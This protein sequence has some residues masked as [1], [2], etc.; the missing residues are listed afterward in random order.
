[1]GTEKNLYTLQVVVSEPEEIE[2]GQ[3]NKT[4]G[5]PQGQ[6]LKA[7]SVLGVLTIPNFSTVWAKP[8]E[9][10]QKRTG[11]LEF[12]PWNDP[13]GQICEIR[14]LPNCPSLDKVYQDEKNFKLRDENVDLVLN[15]G[16]NNFYEDS[17][18]TLVEMLK[19]HTFN[20][21][22][23]SRNPQNHTILFVE[24]DEK[25]VANSALKQDEH[26]FEA[27]GK[28]F[29]IKD[30]SGKLA[31]FA[32]VFNIDPKQQP[33]VLQSALLA[34]VKENPEKFLEDV[35]KFEHYAMTVATRAHDLQIL[36]YT[37]PGE[38]RIADGK[39]SLKIP[40]N[41]QLDKK[42]EYIGE[43]IFEPN[44]YDFLSIMKDAVE[45]KENGF[46]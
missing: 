36:D 9:K 24:Y 6:T 18:R 33:K 28:I 17:D 14:Y 37:E 26:R 35:H 13:K 4:T 2:M 20:G 16:L 8:E 1:M 46:N 3:L 21:D 45:K 11:A 22:N 19:H 10:N 34:I 38:I 32:E 41:L 43:N 12:L 31:V 30:N 25:K 39:H 15:V 29:A 44:V 27:M 42:I 23:K 7:Q 5:L 40:A